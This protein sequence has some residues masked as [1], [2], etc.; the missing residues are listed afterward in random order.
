M[1]RPCSP[2]SLK[3]LLSVPF[4]K[5][6]L[7]LGLQVYCVYMFIDCLPALECQLLG[8]RGCFISC[9]IPKRMS[10]TVV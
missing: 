9:C 1:L 6:L 8:S 5:D 10:V 2:G 7:I 3:Y 4:R